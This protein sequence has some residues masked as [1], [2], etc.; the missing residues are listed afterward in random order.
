MV[1]SHLVATLLWDPEDARTI[2]HDRVRFRRSG[3]EALPDL[4]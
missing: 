3:G 4:R 2:S 1:F